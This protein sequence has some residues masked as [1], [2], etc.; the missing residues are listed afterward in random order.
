MNRKP[1]NKNRFKDIE[2]YSLTITNYCGNFGPFVIK[3]IYLEH[4]EE[5]NQILSDP[6]VDSI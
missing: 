4:K 1:V 2:Q 3:L 6:Q 5:Q